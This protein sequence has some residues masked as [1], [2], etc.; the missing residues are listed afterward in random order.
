MDE[1]QFEFD[2]P[3]ACV[4]ASAFETEEKRRI[5]LIT[6]I[7]KLMNLLRRDENMLVRH[8]IA[9]SRHV[10]NKLSEKHVNGNVTL[11]EILNRLYF[12][13]LDDTGR[14]ML[15]KKDGIMPNA[16]GVLVGGKRMTRS[17]SKSRSKSK[18]K[19]K[20]QKRI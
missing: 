12:V 16:D 20:K 9:Y 8:L 17:K 18:F 6:I 19:S 10:L 3:N 5:N 13:K 2:T 14:K 1:L 11:R 7:V 15:Q 4:G